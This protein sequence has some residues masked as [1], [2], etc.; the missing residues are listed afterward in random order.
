MEESNE[1]AGSAV[2]ATLATTT[3]AAD[4]ENERYFEILQNY[5]L[6]RLQKEAEEKE[7]E[8][9]LLRDIERAKTMSLQ[10][11][12]LGE[13]VSNGYVEDSE[14]TV[15]LYIDGPAMRVLNTNNNSTNYDD[16]NVDSD[17]DVDTPA[18]QR[19]NGLEEDEDNYAYELRVLKERGI[20]P[21]DFSGGQN[22]EDYAHELRVLKERGLLPADFSGGQNR[23]DYAHELRVLKERG[24]LPA[25]FSRQDDDDG[26]DNAHG[27][28]PVDFKEPDEA[29]YADE[30]K[31][32][33]ERGIVP[34]NWGDPRTRNRCLGSP[35]GRR[36]QDRDNIEENDLFGDGVAS[37]SVALM[38]IHHPFPFDQDGI[39]VNWYKSNIPV[40]E[41]GQLY[42]LNPLFPGEDEYETIATDFCLADLEVLKIE[43][44]QSLI[45]LRR[46]R[47]EQEHLLEMRQSGFQ[48]NARYLYHG[49][50]V[51]KVRICEE[52]L[53]A[54]LSMTGCF[55][56]GIYFSDNPKKCIQ[57]VKRSASNDGEDTFML[58]CRVI[59]GHAK[60][61]PK[62]EMDR[63]LKREPEKET[64]TG[65]WR[66]YDSVKGCPI[67][68]NE[69]V[70]YENRRA[71][72][73]YIITFQRA[74]KP[75]DPE[76]SS[77]KSVTKNI[78]D[79]PASYNFVEAMEAGAA[80]SLEEL[81]ASAASIEFD[82]P[83]DKEDYIRFKMTP[84]LWEHMRRIE[85]VRESVRRK[86][87]EDRG[88]HYKNPTKEQKTRD[89]IMW[90]KV[91]KMNRLEDEVIL[92]GPTSTGTNNTATGTNNT[93]T[94]TNNTATGTNNM[95]APTT[96]PE[97]HPIIPTELDLDSVR[98]VEDLLITD[99]LSVT[100]TDDRGVAQLLLER[101]A[102]N[103][104]QAIALYFE[105]QS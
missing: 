17:S 42:T 60:E 26:D 86:R 91:L 11:E 20:L 63:T 25:D 54:R 27:L 33:K 96:D 36:G 47:Q 53:D 101:C 97:E 98:Q 5:E 1:D 15:R 79:L 51:N 39:P 4:E 43:R 18:I 83:D 78:L 62:G 102:M 58:M 41:S 29:D 16:R 55:G 99:F 70:V 6:E 48:L 67:D 28:L 52:G 2:I 75:F 61:Y 82:S 50:T 81:C 31:V 14:E 89:R 77:S 30:L 34:S 76:N 65:G 24:L 64:P 45:L 103:L 95:S 59:L 19:S 8:A 80:A 7:L 46:F 10:D 100:A 22:R 69:F 88:E 12:E 23:E 56:R 40:N 92:P 49:T 13:I 74:E 38:D 9:Q 37:S 66:F 68:F 84:E 90:R 3:T 32:L 57:Y 73:E 44:L 21:A 85:A 72:I 87:A 105:E 104:D 93:A 94:G 71:M 35:A